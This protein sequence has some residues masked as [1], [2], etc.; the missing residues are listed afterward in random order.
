MEELGETEALEGAGVEPRDDVEADL[1]DQVLPPVILSRCFLDRTAD[2]THRFDCHIL[3]FFS[4]NV[5]LSVPIIAY[6]RESIGEWI[7]PP[8]SRNGG[9]QN[10]SPHP[11]KR[12]VDD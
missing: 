10:K 6:T 7:I 5:R 1:R 4:H 2:E 3:F 12:V 9:W 8:P 11:Q